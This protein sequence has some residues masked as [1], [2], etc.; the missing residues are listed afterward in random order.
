M[1]KEGAVA[2]A[3]ALREKYFACRPEPSASGTSAGHLSFMV[4]KMMAGMSQDKTMRWLGY[5]QGCLVY[6][7]LATL[8]EMKEI[9]KRFAEPDHDDTKPS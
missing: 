5:I 2:C 9:S 4:E 6:S 7:G 1:T 8:D 3:T